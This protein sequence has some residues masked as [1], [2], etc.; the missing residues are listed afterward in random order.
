[1]PGPCAQWADRL[2]ALHP[3]DLSEAERAELNEHLATCTACAATWA[4]YLRLAEQL[5]QAPERAT[6]SDLPPQLRLLWLADH[7]HTD[8]QNE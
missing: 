7:A 8:R 6:Q 3:Y 1:M 4:A 2:A 5:R